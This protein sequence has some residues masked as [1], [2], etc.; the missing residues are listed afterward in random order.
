[1]LSSTFQSILLLA[2]AGSAIALPVDAN[3]QVSDKDIGI[4]FKY[5]IFKASEGGEVEKR[6]GDA[7]SFKYPIFKANE[8]FG[9]RDIEKRAN[10]PEQDIGISFKYPIF[11]ANDG[12]AEKREPKGPY[13]D[14]IAAADPKEILG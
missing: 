1:M 3:K 2:F 10:D 11:K 9:E 14:A 13:A 6:G 12:A 5:P 8:G 7:I 4:T